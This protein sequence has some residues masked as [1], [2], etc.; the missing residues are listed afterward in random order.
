MRMFECL[1]NG[2]DVFEQDKKTSVAPQDVP[3]SFPTQC[4]GSGLK[5]CTGQLRAI[6]CFEANVVLTRC[7]V[8]SRFA[9]IK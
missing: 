5:A 6:G 9:Q 4:A 2:S 7:C 1:G 3:S 8:P